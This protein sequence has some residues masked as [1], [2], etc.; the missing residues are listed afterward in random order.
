MEPRQQGHL[1]IEDADIYYR[2]YGKGDRT[3]LLLHGNGEDWTCFLGQIETF[4]SE[5]TVITM[6]SRGHGKSNCGTC[7]LTLKQIGRDAVRLLRLLK[8]PTAILIGFS[9]GANIAM[10]I[11][12]HSTYPLEKLVLAG[13]NLYPSGVKMSVQ[14][15]TIIHHKFFEILAHFLPRFRQKA[16]ILG[17]MVHEPNI[18]PKSLH[19]ISIPTLVL[20][21]EHDMIRAKHT[22][23]IARSIPESK[24]VIIP[25]ANHFIFGK[26]AE[27]T[28]RVILDF[29]NPQNPYPR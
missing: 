9:D 4:A 19:S 2:I 10:E 29:L 14:L 25:N 11:A 26:W 27:Q 5:Y 3:I 22:K 7:P 17:L 16:D 13:G 1:S 28:N 15:P 20:A 18:S 8:I 6:D 23:L 24:L 12:L 21:G